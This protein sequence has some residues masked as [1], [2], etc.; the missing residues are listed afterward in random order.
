MNVFGGVAVSITF[1]NVR[2]FSLE[3]YSAAAW[4]SSSEVIFAI[5]PMRASSLRE[6]SL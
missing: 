2:G 1:T 5:G 4:T 6:P 3:K